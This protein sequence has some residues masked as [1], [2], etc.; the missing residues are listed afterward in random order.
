MS[1]SDAAAGGSLIIS[2]WA[3]WN[4]HRARVWQRERDAESRVTRVRVRFEHAT[5]APSRY[6]ADWGPG[7][8]RRDGLDYRLTLVVVNDGA[9]AVWL[10][11]VWLE[12]NAPLNG[13]QGLDLRDALQ[14]GDRELK[15]RER[16]T[17][18]V[19]VAQ[20]PFDLSGG[21]S[22]TVRLASGEQFESE[23]EHLMDNLVEDIAQHNRDARP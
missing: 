20:V 13:R 15:P 22:G 19:W 5:D 21:F 11:D 10:S 17:A 3:A 9:A 7:D 8:P 1:I 16:F 2:G 14:D 6:A 18:I 23:I 12:E 4:A